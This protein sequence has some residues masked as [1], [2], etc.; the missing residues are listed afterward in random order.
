MPPP[1]WGNG[2]REWGADTLRKR[3][4][5]RVKR[6]RFM[7]LTVGSRCPQGITGPGKMLG[8]SW[9]GR[10]QATQLPASRREPTALPATER[11]Y[12]LL[13]NS[14]I[15]SRAIFRKGRE[16]ENSHRPETLAGNRTSCPR[17]PTTGRV[18]SQAEVLQWK[19]E[20]CTKG[21]RPPEAGHGHGRGTMEH[22]A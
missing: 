13:W 16:W 7:E 18:L 9:G 3:G 6:V 17:V 21:R 1:S 22:E 2:E 19:G 10:G 15:C 5:S 12:A 11:A 8:P 14:A 4:E 20:A